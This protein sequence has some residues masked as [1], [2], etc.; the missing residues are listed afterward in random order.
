M[1]LRAV[2]EFVWHK[3]HT[4]ML[5]D[6]CQNHKKYNT[7]SEGQRKQWLA[8][9]NNLWTPAHQLGQCYFTGQCGK[10]RGNC[11]Y[12]STFLRA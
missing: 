12:C 10:V 3:H 7:E 5:L 9:K 1:K 4:Y 2:K 6:T 8:V 11:T